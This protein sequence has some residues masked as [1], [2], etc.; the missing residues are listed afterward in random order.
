MRLL[1]VRHAES[2]Q[3]AY[4]E[5]LLE[6]MRRGELSPEAFNTAMR[7]AK[8]RGGERT[9]AGSDATL[10]ELGRS[11]AQ[12][13]GAAWAPLLVD[14][15]R[16]GKL[17]VFVSPFKRTLMTA[18]PLMA[19]LASAVPGFRAAVLPAIME[20]GGLTSREDFAHFGRIGALMKG[21]RR[22]EAVAL[23]GSIQW[24]PQGRCRLA[25]FPCLRCS[26]RVVSRQSS[27]QPTLICEVAPPY[28]LYTAIIVQMISISTI[29]SP[30]TNCMEGGRG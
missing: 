5:S 9:D 12:R 16:R 19:A 4:M 3:N 6:L 15:A 28:I 18:D 26:S 10:T 1:L 8:P 24:A 2:E 22:E 13:L 17:L 20:A 14:K 7:D 21:G 27:Y 30:H 23:L 29:I 11:Q 25:C